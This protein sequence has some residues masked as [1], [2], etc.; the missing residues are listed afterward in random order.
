M[1]LIGQLRIAKMSTKAK[2]NLLKL[3]IHIGCLL[4][5]TWLYTQAFNDNLGGDPVKIVIHF[6]GIGALNLLLITLMVS[7]LA[8]RLKQGWVLQVRRL[9]GLYGFTYAVF[10]LI[11]FFVFDLQLDWG[12]LLSEIIE[13]P[14]IMVGMISFVIL[15]SLAITSINQLRRLMGKRWQQLHNFS[16]IALPLIVIHFY[17]SVKSEIIEPSIYIALSVLVLLFKQQKIKRW[18]TKGD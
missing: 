13:R 11:N 16:Y 18:F 2:T 3:L 1:A 14:Y 15:L 7:I 9:L 5:L 6:T 12:L 10:H 17:W 4:P 8:K